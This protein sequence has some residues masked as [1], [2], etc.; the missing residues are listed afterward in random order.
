MVRSPRPTL[1]KMKLTMPNE[2]FANDPL[3]VLARE[4][5]IAFSLIDSCA[6][7]RAIAAPW[8]DLCI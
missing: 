2:D 3:A 1:I 4:A 7:N 5:S 8:L 6:R